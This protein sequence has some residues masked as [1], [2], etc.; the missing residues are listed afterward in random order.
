MF[1]VRPQSKP[2]EWSRAPRTDVLPDKFVVMCYQ[3]ESIVKEQ[4]GNL[5]P[6]ELYT[7]PDPLE[8]EEAF[9]EATDDNTIGPGTVYDWVSNFDKAVEKGTIITHQKVLAS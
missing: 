6:D 1:P 4:I 3:G 5:V 2:F 7:G 9:K 8:P